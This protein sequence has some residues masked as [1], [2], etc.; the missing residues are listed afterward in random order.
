[1]VVIF[2]TTT[3]AFKFNQE[4]VK[5]IILDNKS[6]YDEEALILEKQIEDS[7]NAK[8]MIPNEPRYFDLVA[9]DLI[10][11]QGEG[12]V[13]CKKCIKTY[14]VVE[15]RAATIGCGKKPFFIKREWENRTKYPLK[16]MKPPELCGGKGYNCPK[17]H[18]LI[19][20]I[21]WKTF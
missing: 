13:F 6:K 3:A 4:A 21:T 17:G 18:T 5:K 15:L 9:L 7:D 20:M 14:D 16:K 11:G 1:M 10:A 19:S 8:I 12:E 2:R